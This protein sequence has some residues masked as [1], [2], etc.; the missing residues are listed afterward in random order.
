M[1]R[2]ALMA[3]LALSGCVSQAQFQKNMDSYIGYSESALIAGLGVP[4]AT[5][6]VGAD[7]YLSYRRS[8]SGVTPG[9]A[10]TYQSTV[11]GNTVYSTPIGGVAPRAYSVNCTVDFRLTGGVVKSYRYEGNGCFDY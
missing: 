7:K 11:I 3:L 6:A 1:R 2:F 8:A 9:V 4:D 10:P 5:Y